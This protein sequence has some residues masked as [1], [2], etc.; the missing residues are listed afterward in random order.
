MQILSETLGADDTSKVFIS[1]QH[2]KCWVYLS[3]SFS[4][5]TVTLEASVDNSTFSTFNVDGVDQTF[6]AG[7]F[8]LY[9][10]PGGIFFRF[11][12]SN[13]GSPDIDIR[14]AGNGVKVLS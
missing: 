12:V 10:L 3:G 13:G 2:T 7:T 8:K 11:D 1:Q 9:D 5:Q 4:S 14:V 6:T